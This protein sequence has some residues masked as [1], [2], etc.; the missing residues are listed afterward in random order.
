MGIIDPFEYLS[1]KDKSFIERFGVP[2]IFTTSAV[3]IWNFLIYSSLNFAF[4]LE[5]NMYDIVLAILVII[6]ALDVIY[7]IIKNYKQNKML[8]LTFLSWWISY[9]Y[10]NI[11][12]PYTCSMHSRYMVVPISIGIIYLGLGMKN[13]K[14]KVL[15]IQVYI[16]STTI[17][18][19]SIFKFILY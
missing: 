11:S 6:L 5:I 3:N 13:E 4:K 12:M 10:L 14:N 16:S 2:N 17:F 15:K 9:F 7:F 19:M 8:A 1:I 18:L